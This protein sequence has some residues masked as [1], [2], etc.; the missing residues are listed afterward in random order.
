MPI[1]YRIIDGFPGYRVGTDGSFWSQWKPAGNSPGNN[2]GGGGWILSGEWYQRTLKL[3]RKGDISVIIQHHGIRKHISLHRLIL[4]TFVG[5]CPEGM[6]AC[7]YPDP[8]HT[9]NHLSNLRWDT[10]LENAQDCIRL[11]RR[12]RGEQ[13]GRAKLDAEKVLAIRSLADKGA[14]PLE[15]SREYGVSGMQIKRIVSRL[16]WAHIQ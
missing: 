15:L 10:K 16:Q 12:P 8:D 7:H 14:T 6:E 13:H 3:N 5:P 11:G 4:E 9:N 2:K 1:C